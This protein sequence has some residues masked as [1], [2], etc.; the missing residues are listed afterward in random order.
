MRRRAIALYLC[1]PAIVAVGALVI[2]VQREPRGLDVLLGAGFGGFLFYATPFLVW[3]F[4]IV[5]VKLTG[6]VAHAGF[7]AALIVLAFFVA[8]S[9]FGTRD[10]SGLPLHWMVYLPFAFVLQASF[11]VVAILYVR[12]RRRFGT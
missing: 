11:I 12:L 4:V 7:I 10:P 5:A 2:A 6:P 3:A 9:F 8:V 1:I